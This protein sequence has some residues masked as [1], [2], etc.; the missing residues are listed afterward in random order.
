MCFSRAL[1]QHLIEDVVLKRIQNFVLTEENLNRL[2]QLINEECAK[3]ISDSENQRSF[4]ASEL[5]NKHQ[6]LGSTVRNA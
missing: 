2:Q 3:V 6:R 1:P 4:L 5:S